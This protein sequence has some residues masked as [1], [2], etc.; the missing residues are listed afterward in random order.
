MSMSSNEFL[1]YINIIL[2]KY[3][4]QFEELLKNKDRE[5]LLSLC[6]LI[7]NESKEILSNEQNQ[8]I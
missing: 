5:G 3:S 8:I 1:L 4:E 6:E 7:N 2:S